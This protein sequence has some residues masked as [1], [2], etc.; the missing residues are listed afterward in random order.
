MND[1]DKVNCEDTEVSYAGISKRIIA[2][3]IDHILLI[4][5]TFIISFFLSPFSASTIHNFH[6]LMEM[7]QDTA[8]V[9]ITFQWIRIL[10]IL[11]S[12]IFLLVKFVGTP[13]QLLLGI[14]VKDINTLKN[15]TPKK[16]AIRFFFFMVVNS[17][18]QL[19]YI[20]H[21]FLALPILI[22]LLAVFDKR[23]QF[24]HDKIANTVVI[25]YKPINV[26]L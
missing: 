25:D 26:F 8:T 22:L 21:W 13:G 20:S 7:N 18:K 19:R 14:Y 11:I 1:N 12:E 10:L 17:T 3:I 23:K 6:D 9:I 15:V 4:A 24:L 2:V 16:A 5:I